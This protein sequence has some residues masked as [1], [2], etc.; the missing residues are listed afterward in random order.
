MVIM[1]MYL[2]SSIH[3]SWD[4]MGQ[5]GKVT[6]LMR[7]LKIQDS[8]EIWLLSIWLHHRKESVD[9]WQIFSLEKM[10]LQASSQLYSFS[11]I[12][13]ERNKKEIRKR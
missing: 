6:M 11:S 1:P 2:L 13:F 9:G 7:A 3:I 4:A 10:V 5:V 8:V 12:I